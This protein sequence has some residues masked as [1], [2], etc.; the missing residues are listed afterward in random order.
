MFILKEYHVFGSRFDSTEYALSGAGE[1]R[2]L[3]KEAA[4]NTVGIDA[5]RLFSAF[6]AAS[7]DN[8][9]V[10]LTWLAVPSSP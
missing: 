4:E 8:T 9:S 1:N 3:V 6:T 5:S 2:T 10:Y 7:A